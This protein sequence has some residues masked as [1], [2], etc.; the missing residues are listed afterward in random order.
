MIMY[1]EGDPIRHCEENNAVTY[2]DYIVEFP[3]IASCDK[4]IRKTS[5]SM[6]N[7]VINKSIN[8]ARH[9]THNVGEKYKGESVSYL[10]Y[11]FESSRPNPVALDTASSAAK[12]KDY[13]KEDW[14]LKR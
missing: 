11:K 8:I 2:F 10:H 9:F 12:Y 6:N 3:C 1:L 13:E 5:I 7:P 4:G 14:V